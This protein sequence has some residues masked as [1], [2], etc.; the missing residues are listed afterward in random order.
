MAVSVVDSVTVV[1]SIESEMTVVGGLVLSGTNFSKLPPVAV[2]GMTVVGMAVVGM[3]VVT[4]G[5][6]VVVEKMDGNNK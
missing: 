2:V 1:V 6:T 3:T 5:M 4:V